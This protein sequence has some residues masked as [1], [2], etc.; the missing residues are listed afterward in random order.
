MARQNHENEKA[1]QNYLAELW[2]RITDIFTKK[3][4][5]NVNGV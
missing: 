1:G 3:N 4:F 5:A 2:G